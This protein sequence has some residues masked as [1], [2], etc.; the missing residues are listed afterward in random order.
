MYMT[1]TKATI[2][3]V[4]AGVIATSGITAL[5]LMTRPQQASALEQTTWGC[6]K[7]CHRQGGGE[8]CER[9]CTK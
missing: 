4:L 9:M 1:K 8:A 5:I 3:T 2:L 6:I 7:E